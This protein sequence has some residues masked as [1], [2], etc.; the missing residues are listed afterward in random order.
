MYGQ[1]IKNETV[2]TDAS[3]VEEIQFNE[4]D[5]YPAGLYFILIEKDGKSVV[6]KVIKI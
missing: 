1:L 4:L 6:E 5:R 3:Q 2:F